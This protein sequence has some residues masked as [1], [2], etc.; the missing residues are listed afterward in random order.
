MNRKALIEVGEDEQERR[1]QLNK[2]SLVELTVQ[3][4]SRHGQYVMAIIGKIRVA[5]VGF[6]KFVFARVTFNNWASFR[7][8]SGSYIESSP[9]GTGDIFAF[10]FTRRDKRPVNVEFALSGSLEGKEYWEN[11]NGKNYCFHL[12]EDPLNDI[13]T[14]ESEPGVVTTWRVAE[15]S[16]PDKQEE[17]VFDTSSYPH[18]EAHPLTPTKLSYYT[19]LHRAPEEEVVPSKAP[20]TKHIRAF[21]ALAIGELCEVEDKPSNPDDGAIE[22]ITA[23]FAETGVCMT[24]EETQDGIEVQATEPTQ[25]QQTVEDPI[26]PIKITKPIDDESPDDVFDKLENP[27]E[28]MRV[29][30]QIIEEPG[31]G[32]R[33]DGER[34]DTD[35]TANDAAGQQLTEQDPSKKKDKKQ[36]KDEKKKK[37]EAKKQEKSDKKEKKKSKK[38]KAPPVPQ[39]QQNEDQKPDSETQEQK[40]GKDK[41][42]DLQNGDDQSVSS[43]KEKIGDEDSPKKPKKGFLTKMACCGKAEPD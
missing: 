17:I 10:G 42:P 6:E 29:D 9:D 19:T 1:L 15:G 41:N 24:G 3:D 26:E 2:L 30:L 20:D 22:A 4:E 28:E 14:G 27:K 21:N 39:T 43:K 34:K 37:K 12:S 25:D 8:Y 31:D 13:A 36:T 16:S 23:T 7:D 40:N 33:P 11:N 18:F 35:L 32:N 5:N 38:S